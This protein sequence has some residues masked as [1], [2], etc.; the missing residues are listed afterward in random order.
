MLKQLRLR[1]QH[2]CR[3]PLT[4]VD[5]KKLLP[6]QPIEPWQT[7]DLDLSR[8]ASRKGSFDSHVSAEKGPEAIS[9]LACQRYIVSAIPPAV[10]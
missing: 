10:M 7:P 1:F 8:A 3:F 6:A 4:S 5:A 2:T 9:G